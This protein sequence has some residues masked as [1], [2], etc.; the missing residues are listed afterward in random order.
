MLLALLLPSAAPPDV[1]GEGPT[2]GHFLGDTKGRSGVVKALGLILSWG[3]Q[4]HVSCR[5]ARR[6]RCLF[7][8]T[9]A[10]PRESQPFSPPRALA[11]PHLIVT[12][13]QLSAS[14]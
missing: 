14:R 7:F 2:S 1:N 13:W 9:A 8:C 11:L 3:Q 12:A 4:K 6:T 5:S 10:L